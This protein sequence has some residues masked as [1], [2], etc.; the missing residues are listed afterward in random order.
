MLLWAGV[1]HSALHNSDISLAGCNH[2]NSSSKILA[3]RGGD[4]LACYLGAARN[5]G[6][7]NVRLVL[8]LRP[9]VECKG[10]GLRPHDTEPTAGSTGHS[11]AEEVTDP[12]PFAPYPC[13]RPSHALSQDK[14]LKCKINLPD[15]VLFR[16]G[17]L[18]AWWATNKVSQSQ[19]LHAC[20]P[21]RHSQLRSCLLPLFLHRRATSRG[22]QARTPPSRRSG[23]AC[24][25]SQAR[26]KPTTAAL[27]PSAGT[28]TADRSCS[29]PRPSTSWQSCSATAW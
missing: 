1:Q 20:M 6:R 17:Q 2:L 16:Y 27:L 10:I 21:E 11:R 19:P 25:R 5:N 22:M 23:S 18:S 29:A 26:M 4:E 3:I 24:C 28:E 15:T 9:H 14:G 8:L 13:M 12:T 7:A